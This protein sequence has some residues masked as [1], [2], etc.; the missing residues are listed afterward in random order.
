[1]DQVVSRSPGFL[2]CVILTSDGSGAA[3]VALYDG[4]GTKDDPLLTVKCPDGETKV[5]NFSP[6][7]ILHK[8]LYLDVGSNVTEVLV[9][10]VVRQ[11]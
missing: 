4:V 8:G 3:S 6:A 1:M 10:I 5:I 2:G 9:E 7:L 11:E